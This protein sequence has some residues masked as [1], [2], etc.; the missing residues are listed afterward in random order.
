MD[1]NDIDVDKSN[2]T[3]QGNRIYG[4]V[5]IDETFYH[6]KFCFVDFHSKTLCNDYTINN[7][8]V[9][10]ANEETITANSTVKVE[11]DHTLHAIWKTNYTLGDVNNDGRINAVDASSVLAYYARISSNQNGGYTEEQQLSADVNH[12]GFINAVDASNILAYY[13]YLSTTKEDIIPLETF[14][15]KSK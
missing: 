12:D 1:I 11:T 15:N 9:V 5:K 10:Q 14:M 4:N 6:P 13:A 2:Y 3:I 7:F 8:Y